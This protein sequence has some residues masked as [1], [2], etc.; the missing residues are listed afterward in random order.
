MSLEGETNLLE[1]Y[2]FGEFE[3]RVR[4]RML[5]LDGKRRAIQLLPFRLLLAL[6]E[7]PGMV[8]SRE[9]LREKLW[10]GKNF[11]DFDSGLRVAARKLRAALGDDASAPV[12]IQTV[13]GRGY[14]LIADVV[15]VP[16]SP[17]DKSAEALVPLPLVP[18]PLVPFHGPVEAIAPP[19]DADIP[20]NAAPQIRR[21]R[22][23]LAAIAIVMFTA[24]AIGGAVLQN[25]HSPLVSPDD[26]VINGGFAGSVGTG[27][28]DRTLAAALEVKLEESPYF[29][30]ISESAFRQFVSNPSTAALGDVLHACSSLGGQVLVQGQI[31]HRGRQY[32]VI[33]SAWRCNSGKRLT[34]QTAVA[35]SEASLITALDE[36]TINMRRRLGEPNASLQQFNVPLPQA[37]TGSLAALS[38][39]NLAE[40]K[41]D[42]G[43]EPESIPYY[44]LAITL[45]PRF[46]LAYAK[47]GTVY[48]NL[49]D[50]S[51]SKANNQMAFELRGRTTDREQLYIAARYYASVTGQIDDSIHTYQIWQSV[52]ARDVV[53]VNNLAVLYLAL[54]RP[55]G[56]IELARRAIQLDPGKQLLYGTLAQAYLESGD[57][58]GVTALCRDPDRARTTV[59]WFHLT[60]LRADFAGRDEGG[61]QRE[62]DWAK[63]TGQESRMLDTE[64]T[65]AFGRG[66][67]AKS[68]RLFEAAIANA[69]NG[70]MAD[71]AAQIELD[72]A[73]FNSEIGKT[74][75]ARQQAAQ[76]LSVARGP[77]DQAF[78]ALAFARAG[79]IARAVQVVQAITVQKSTDTLL[80]L[81]IL[82][83]INASLALRKGLPRKA[84][85]ALEPT[86]PY[87]CYLA[88]ELAPAYYRGMAYL[89]NN[90]PRE[91]AMEFKKVL[92]HST[93]YPESPYIVLSELELGR[94]TQLAGD[95]TSATRIF[96]SLENM[97][98]NCDPDFPPL[99]ELRRYQSEATLQKHLPRQSSHPGA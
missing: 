80:N 41:H 73:N 48:D 28:L 66:Q 84:A 42:R 62:I 32:S 59:F 70:G 63:G 92:A 85:E 24:L 25:A 79:D 75:R 27:D 5:L 55:E 72:E 56:T 3:V 77:T 96:I 74:A 82:P 67:L 93:I 33:L 2:R 46:A 78:A 1:A 57:L 95:T 45:D 50:A 15:S 71:I 16:G 12:Y 81:A 89:R 34:T 98:K 90:Q 76:A 21:R 14:Q 35:D 43:M 4:S 9:E 91:A 23:L 17:P 22:T 31:L 39:F 44:R 65:I 6:L 8:V 54:G 36:A 87:D 19:E 83:S 30:L 20:E 52:Y 18:F 38:A 97:W 40:E 11:A 60:C 26:K 13:S 86:R 61:V 68:H 29:N 94:V 53:P 51:E 47:L 58:S 88:L 7:K 49:G 99:Q 10:Y 37:T 69:M 64:A